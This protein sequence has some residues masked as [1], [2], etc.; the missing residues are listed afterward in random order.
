MVVKENITSRLNFLLTAVRK[1]MMFDQRR[2]CL[3]VF[4]ITSDW[5]QNIDRWDVNSSTIPKQTLKRLDTCDSIP[6][7]KLWNLVV[8][9][10]TWFPN[11]RLREVVLI[12]CIAVEVRTNQGEEGSVFQIYLL[13]FSYL[14]CAYFILD[15]YN[16]SKHPY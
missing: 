12:I 1:N 3:D 6:A 7:L 2:K 16:F 4:L 11:K 15:F 14:F 5:H 9:I 8:V 13:Q 10:F